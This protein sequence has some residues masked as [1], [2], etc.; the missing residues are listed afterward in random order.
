M[1][2]EHLNHFS[3][4]VDRDTSPERIGNDIARHI[5]NLRLPSTSGESLVL[6]SVNGNTKEFDITSGFVPIGYATFG[7][8]AI[9]FSFNPTTG[10]GE[11]GTFPSPKSPGGGFARVYSPLMNFTGDIDPRVN[12]DATRMPFRTTCL[13]FSCEHQIEAQARIASNGAIEVFFTDFHNP[14]RHINTGFDHRTGVA[15]GKPYW[16]GV[17]PNPSGGGGSGS[18]DGVVGCSILENQ[19]SVLFGSCSIPEPDDSSDVSLLSQGFLK[20]GTWIFLP[21]YLTNDLSPT[22]F[23]TEIG[24]I[25]IYTGANDP[26]M[27][28][29]GNETGTDTNIRVKM[30]LSPIDPSYQYL[31]IGFIHY[32]DGGVN[33]GLFSKIFE[34]PAGA[35]ELYV[36]IIGDEDVIDL[37]TAEIAARKPTDD[38]VRSIEQH[39]NRIWGANWKSSGPPSVS[40]YDIGKKVTVSAPGPKDLILKED[41]K[42]SDHYG[43]YWSDSSPGNSIPFQ[44]KNWKN[45]YDHVGYFRGEAYAFAIVF[46]MNNGKLSPPIPVLGRDEWRFDLYGTNQKGVLRMPPAT[47]AGYGLID[48]SGGPDHNKLRILGV[49]FD[50]SAVPV[51]Q[52][53]ENICG[54]FFVRAERKPRLIYQGIMAPTWKAESSMSPWIGDMNDGSLAMARSRSSVRWPG[55]NTPNYR[56][57]LDNEPNEGMYPFS[58]ASST[59]L[60]NRHDCNFRVPFKYNEDGNLV[61]KGT[62]AHREVVCDFKTHAIFSPDHWMMK[63]F[64]DGSYTIKRVYQP[65]FKPLG[66][67]TNELGSSG[68]SYDNDKAWWPIL[69]WDQIGVAAMSAGSTAKDV[70]MVNVKSRESNPSEG[71]IVTRFEEG[72]NS[73]TY[74]WF[75]FRRQPAVGE[76]RHVRNRDMATRNCIGVLD[77]SLFSDEGGSNLPRHGQVVNIYQFDPEAEDPASIY[78]PAMELYY[79]ISKT[80]SISEWGKKFIEYRGDCFLQR[81]YIKEMQDSGYHDPGSDTSSED[82][83]NGW[84][85][86]GAQWQNNDPSGE[87]YRYVTSHYSPFGVSIGLV[88][89][90]RVNIAM[91]WRRVNNEVFPGPGLPPWDAVP[92]LVGN[93]DYGDGDLLDVGYN[94]VLGIQGALGYDQYVPQKGWFPTRVRW[95]GKYLN[96]STVR[97]GY[98]QWGIDDYRDYDH[99]PGEIMFLGEVGGSLFSVHRHAIRRHFTSERYASDQNNGASF[100]LS[101]GDTLAEQSQLLS[102]ETGTQ[103]QWSVIVTDSAIYGIDVDLRSAWRIGAGFQPISDIKSFQNDIYDIIEQ[104]VPEYSDIVAQIG[105]NPVCNEGIVGWYDRKHREVGWTFVWNLD[106]R[107]TESIVYSEKY[108]VYGGRRYGNRFLGGGEHSPFY[109]RINEDMYSFDPNGGNQFWLHDSSNSMATFWGS[110]EHSELSFVVNPS[111]FTKTKLYQ[112]MSML[113]SDPTPSEV[114]FRT[115]YHQSELSPFS[116]SP[117]FWLEPRYLE[118]GWRFTVPKSSSVTPGPNQE[119]QPESPMRGKWMEATVRWKTD[120]NIIVRSVETKY[121]ISN[122]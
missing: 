56:S 53:D 89:E 94:K 100:V 82:G 45:T 58:A 61:M 42:I 87:G 23:L 120:E 12:P 109:L 98:L 1:I 110:V 52:I 32:T 25:N 66:W 107:K 37:S 114:K 34:I 5:R 121:T 92:Y 76:T 55:F 118:N 102:A 8:I 72:N 48:T 122:Q 117:Y 116:P 95:S 6:H 7:S 74:D 111:G 62:Y 69:I 85:I 33:T 75:Y 119:Y 86:N 17:T 41:W 96:D 39:D 91:R 64:S 60:N 99:N 36:E 97:D 43:E 57:D 73:A 27:M 93:N 83:N 10:E 81:T 47:S 84:N 71:G 22:S 26:N 2:Q 44:H 90:N 21:R 101:T 104:R 106:G 77:Y 4:G 19:I 3:R 70:R 38:T 115:E 13:K 28:S 35:T 63:G 40:L 20:S 105:D 18:G 103:H 108:D 14:F 30:R 78:D 31:E 68:S 80:Y 9:I 11:I 79:R 29:V 46:V 59:N 24:P 51:D 88:T 15:V 50:T 67:G 54:F 112:S 65:V 49:Q 113:G 16:D